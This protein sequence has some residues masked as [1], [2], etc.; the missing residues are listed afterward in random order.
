MGFAE[1]EDALGIRYEASYNRMTKEI[2]GVVEDFH[3]LGMR[4]DVEPLLLDIEPSLFNTITLAVNIK[5]IKAVM[6]HVENTWKDHFP[7]VPFAFTFLDE[8]F[9]QVY[10]YEDQMSRML[11]IIAMLGFIIA[12]LGLFGLASFMVHNRVKE[13]GIRRV[14]GAGRREIVSLLSGKFVVLIV[15][16]IAAACP[17][18]YFAMNKWLQ[19]F[20]YRVDMGALVFVAASAGALLIALLTVGLQGLRAA[21]ANPADSIR[22]E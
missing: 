6:A 19:D 12:C 15:I 5:D 10:R 13:I 22:N 16:S 7:G 17:A 9:D 20:A 2:V 21:S 3:I 4:E 1:P 11:S 8:N 14:L 18:A